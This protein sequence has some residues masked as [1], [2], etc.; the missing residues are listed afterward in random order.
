MSV[1]L[2]LVVAAADVV[3]V[4]AAAD[5]ALITRW[6]CGGRSDGGGSL[7]RDEGPPAE[8]VERPWS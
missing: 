3:P 8:I 2:H 6:R 4:V 1:D 5:A 7:G